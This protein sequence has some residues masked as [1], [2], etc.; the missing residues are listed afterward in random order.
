V[1]GLAITKIELA[2]AQI[3]DVY[4]NICRYYLVDTYVLRR[5][6]TNIL[7]YWYHNSTNI[8]VNSSVSTIFWYRLS[9]R[10]TGTYPY[11]LSVPGDE[12]RQGGT[13]P[14]VVDQI[15]STHVVIVHITVLVTVFTFCI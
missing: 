1:F 2:V 8:S 5:L 4:V 13:I 6:Q 10:T 11:V 7:G 3:S 14:D 15:N 9:F 12:F